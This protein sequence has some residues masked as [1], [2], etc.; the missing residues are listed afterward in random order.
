MDDDFIFVRRAIRGSKVKK[1]AT[2]MRIRLLLRDRNNLQASSLFDSVTDCSWYIIYHYG[3]DADFLD[4]VKIT[5]DSFDILLQEFSKHYVIRSGPGR[6]GR[7]RRMRDK[8]C[9]LALLLHTYCSAGERVTW[10]EMFG[11][12]KRGTINGEDDS[13]VFYTDYTISE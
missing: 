1:I 13:Y 4:T 12:Q 11:V 6:L 5:R 3:S 2:A 8:H 9:I 7:P 10:S